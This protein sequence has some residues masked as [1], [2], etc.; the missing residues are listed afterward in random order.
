VNVKLFTPY[1]AQQEFIDKFVTTDDLFGTLVA[2]RG[3]GKTL[4]AINFA[5]YWALQKKNQKLGWCS[6]TFSQAKSVLDQIVSAAPDLVQSSNRMEAVITFIN[7]STIKFLSSDSADNIRGFRFTHLILDEAAYIKDSV[8]STIL[9]PTL[10][11]NGKKCLLVSTPAGKNHFF[12]W[13]MKNDVVS[14]RITLEECPY[15]SKTLLDE[16]KASL[17]EDIYATEYLAEFRDSANDVF[18]SIEKVAFVGEYRRGGDVYVGIDTGL[19]DDASVMT[20]ISPIGRVMNV[21]S[22]SQ[23]DINTAATLF[24]KEL[25]G[26]N[27]VGGYIEVNGIGRAMYDLVGPKHRRIKKFTTNQNNKTELVRKLINDIET[28]TIELPSAELCPDL[29]REFATYTY[30]LS[31]TGKLSFGHSSGAHDD[32]IDSLMLANYSRVQFME[33]KPIRISGHR[34][35]AVS[36]GT[37]K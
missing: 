5:L 17:P 18:K 31:P 25:Q 19:S 27:V 14:H 3:S 23:T 22:I 32:F 10:N 24:L 26:Y 9:L 13:Y 4:A 30:K 7:G 35:T 12:N 33:R 34:K 21:V 15:I 36:F 28:M 2:P 6:P 29:H 8:I 37:P 11:P 1:K 16:A 20:L